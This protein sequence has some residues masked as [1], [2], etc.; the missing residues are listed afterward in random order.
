MLWSIFYNPISP[1]QPASVQVQFV[2]PE[3]SSETSYSSTQ[4]LPVDSPSYHLISSQLAAATEKRC[5]TLCKSAL[6]ELEK[7]LLQRHYSSPFSTFLAAVIILACIE[8]IAALFKGWEDPSAPPHHEPTNESE[9]VLNTAHDT[10]MLNG[11]LS[12]NLEHIPQSDREIAQRLLAAANPSTPSASQPTR[13]A[14]P[15]VTPTNGATT[16]DHDVAMTDSMLETPSSNANLPD[17]SPLQ[18]PPSHSSAPQS[19]ERRSDSSPGHHVHTTTT[20]PSALPRYPLD[21]PPNYYIHQGERFAEILY[22]LLKMRGLPPKTRSD[23]ISSS[24]SSSPAT[25]R[26]RLV[27]VEQASPP[28]AMGGVNGGG[29]GETETR[30]AS[31]GGMSQA[32]AGSEALVKEWFESLGDGMRSETEGESGG[33][34][35]GGLYCVPIGWFNWV[36]VGVGGG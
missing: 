29:M 19:A 24:S 20:S 22:M 31:G 8:R 26:S 12:E 25:P 33:A 18:P 32:M 16:T 2:S 35:G 30:R 6:N 4:P 5:A 34:C 9:T 14:Q 1:P 36:G 21:R 17:S 27:P 11:S 7:R 3:N 13:Q 10:P 15:P 23:P 28:A